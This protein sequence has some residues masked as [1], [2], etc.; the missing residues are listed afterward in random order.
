MKVRLALPHNLSNRDFIYQLGAL[1]LLIGSLLVLLSLFVLPF[2]ATD[3]V[4]GL[5][6]VVYRHTSQ[7]GVEAA[8]SSLGTGLEWNPFYFFGIWVIMV[9]PLRTGVSGL[10]RKL[11]KKIP[12]L[13]FVPAL[14]FALLWWI[15]FLSDRLGRFS[16]LC[17]LAC[18]DSPDHYVQHSYFDVG[19]AYLLIGFLV[20]PILGG[21]LMAAASRKGEQSRVSSTIA[22]GQ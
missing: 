13:C 1:T 4:G 3:T 12:L 17:S 19:T 20:L 6:G 15:N 16:P 18:Y 21:I 11:P 7:T 22:N 10:V 9:L 5:N 14:C 8:F 2:I